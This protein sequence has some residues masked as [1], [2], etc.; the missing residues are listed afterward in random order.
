MSKSTELLQGTVDLLILKVLSLEPNNED[1][2]NRKARL[3][4]QQKQ[5][6]TTPTPS[7]TPRPRRH[8]PPD[9]TP[10]PKPKRPSP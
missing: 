6:N 9:E 5:A 2:K 10:T 7:L 1:A 8:L 3:E 4:Y